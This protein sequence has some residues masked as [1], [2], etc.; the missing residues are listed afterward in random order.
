MS[1]IGTTNGSLFIHTT[2]EFTRG[3]KE[4]C[5]NREKS[6]VRIMHVNEK[7]H[8]WDTEQMG[9]CLSIAERFFNNG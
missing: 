4:E 3:S 1:M 7:E 6:T 8:H 2:E 5:I 9:I